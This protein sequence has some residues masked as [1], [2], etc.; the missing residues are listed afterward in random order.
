MDYDGDHSPP[1]SL[2]DGEHQEEWDSDI[3]H[4]HDDFDYQDNQ[5]IKDECKE[6]FQSKDFIMESQAIPTVKKYL[7]AGGV[8]QEFVELLADSYH[9]VAQLANLLADWLIVAGATVEE[10]QDVVEK[11]LKDLIVKNFDPKKADSIFSGAGQPPSWI[12]EMIAHRPW[13]VM[14]YELAEK[15]PECLMLNFTIKMISEAGYETEVGTISTACSQLEVFSKLLKTSIPA[16]FQKD[17]NSFIM[18]DFVKSCCHAKHMYIYSQCLL[19]EISENLQDG[20]LKAV[21]RRL[22]FELQKGALHNGH[23][24]WNL[25]LLLMG[26]GEYPRVFSSLLSLVTKQVLNPGDMTILYKSYT[27]NDPPSVS[28]IRVP[29]LLDILVGALFTPSSN[30][31]V[32]HQS[33][34]IYI[35]AYAVSVHEYW[36]EEKRESVYTEELNTTI[37]ALENVNKVCSN[38]IG[39]SSI[40]LNADVAVLYQSISFPVVAMGLLKWIEFC[41]SEINY[42]KVITEVSPIQVVMLD[43]ICSCHPLQH[44]NV[45]DLL[46][47]LFERNYPDLDT[48]M[49]LEFK[50]T[51]V[52]RM[53]HM[54]SRGYIMPVVLYMKDCM[55]KQVTD[56]SLL[57]HFVTEMLEMIAPPYSTDFIASMLPIV[58]NKE[59]T[60]ALKDGSDDV[61]QFLVHCE[62]G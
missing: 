20:M 39:S 35:L 55:D 12:D 28:F 27:S 29:V 7:N 44:E 50:K 33:K 24:V 4:P 8:P 15:Y 43:E 17:A 52:D 46:K 59:V 25:S 14:C 51:L 30:I 11:H 57:R 21:A 34:Y 23:D 26:C 47:D 6:V 53:I 5:L 18:D 48:L 32:E 56:V 38:D 1:R 58:Q 19:H 36:E 16:F 60:G 9:G 42:A 2:Y 13:R 61:T 41:M 62:N 31:P 37:E 40:H 54:L 3:G 10:V 45:F 22:A 49:E